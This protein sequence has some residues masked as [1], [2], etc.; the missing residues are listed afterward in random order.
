MTTYLSMNEG[1]IRESRDFREIWILDY[2]ESQLLVRRQ[3][4][5]WG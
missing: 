3:R 5:K 4:Q 2:R 1:Q